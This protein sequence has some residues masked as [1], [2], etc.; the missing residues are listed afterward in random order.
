MHS[1]HMQ[2]KEQSDIFTIEPPRKAVMEL[3][4]TCGGKNSVSV[5]QEE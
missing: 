1:M 4:M 5:L 2:E 3:M